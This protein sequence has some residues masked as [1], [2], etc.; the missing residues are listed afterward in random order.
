MSREM[1]NWPSRCKHFEQDLCLIALLMEKAGTG[2]ALFRNLYRDYL[3]E[4]V[5]LLEDRKVEQACLQFTEITPMWVSVAALIDH[6]G[7]TGSP[8]EL[9]QGSVLLQE[10]ADKERTAMELL[11]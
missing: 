4:C 9:K 2:G 10:I 3:K 11:L 5:E 6:A 7:K 8:Q 1:L